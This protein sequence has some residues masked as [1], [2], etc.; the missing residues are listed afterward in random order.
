MRWVVKLL[1]LPQDTFALNVLQLNNYPK[2]MRFLVFSSRRAVAVKLLRSVLASDA[3]LDSVDVTSRLLTFLA[4]LV[5]DEDDTP[6]DE[7]D[8]AEAFKEE[9][10]LMAALVHLMRHD[11]TDT[12][13]RVRTSLCLFIML[14]TLQ[15]TRLVV[16]LPLRNL[17]IQIY[18]TARKFFG[19]GGTRR[20]PHTLVPLVFS[21]L[22][23][24]AKVRHRERMNQSVGFP[25]RKVF[26]F[27]HE[28]C[29]ALASSHPEVL[30][31]SPPPSGLCACPSPAPC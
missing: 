10:R 11:D 30:T 3:K 18:G 29:T 31:L 1:Q 17:T 15:L 14:D 9:Q 26:Q 19:H 24:A 6:A 22:A 2:L 28:I 21:S 5:K 8:N 25:S 23:L 12:Q 13:F 7:E 4:P 20:M 27:I 16:G